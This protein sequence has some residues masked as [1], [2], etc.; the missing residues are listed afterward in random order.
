MY[1]IHK[2]H[3]DIP[4]TF[5]SPWPPLSAFPLPALTLGPVGGSKSLPDVRLVVLG[6]D[7]GDAADHAA[8]GAG[9]AAAALVGRLRTLAAR[10]GVLRRTRVVLV[11][12]VV[13]QPAVD[14]LIL[15]ALADAGARGWG[16][17]RRWRQKT[18]TAL[19]AV[20]RGHGW[21]R[22]GDAESDCVR[23]C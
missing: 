6:G 16:G 13:R 7:D 21:S 3:S 1:K 5:Q 4:P 22:E 18:Q 23:Q 9:E 11:G 8:E 10:G 15:L 17:R 19:I 2:L 12:H 20:S 14:D